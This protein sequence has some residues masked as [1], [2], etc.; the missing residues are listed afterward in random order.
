MSA[1]ATPTSAT[2]AISSD[3]DGQR[4]WGTAGR[5]LAGYDPCIVIASEDMLI[6]V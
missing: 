5:R 4:T 2:A 1:S 6:D 3:L